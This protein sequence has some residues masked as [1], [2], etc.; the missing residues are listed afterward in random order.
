[1]TT[2]LTPNEEQMLYDLGWNQDALNK[3]GPKVQRELATSKMSKGLYDQQNP[4]AYRNSGYDSDGAKLDSPVKATSTKNINA[5]SAFNTS[6]ADSLDPYDDL[7]G[8][9]DPLSTST[10]PMSSIPVDGVGVGSNDKPMNTQVPSLYSQSNP[11]PNS[12]YGQVGDGQSDW[13]NPADWGRDFSK[14]GQVM[15]GYDAVTGEYSDTK[16]DLDQKRAVQQSEIDRNNA[17]MDNQGTSWNDWANIGLGAVGTGMQMSMH[18]DRKD[19]L[20]NS[21]KALEQQTA[22]AEEAHNTKMA[23]NASYGS[24][25]SGN[26]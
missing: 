26:P 5:P 20:S 9:Q 8:Y 3:L 12:V 19:F 18:G 14:Q 21:N 22:N 2:A 15:P 11:N 4:N 6:G 16:F 1:M 17:I 13:Y 23:N 25:F 24:A 7:D 10:T